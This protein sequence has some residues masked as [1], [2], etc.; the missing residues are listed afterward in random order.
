MPPEKWWGDMCILSTDVEK[1]SLINEKAQ[2]ARTLIHT[3]VFHTTQELEVA[4][5]RCALPSHGNRFRIVRFHW[6][7]YEQTVQ[8]STWQE[9]MEMVNAT[10]SG[11]SICIPYQERTGLVVLLG[12]CANDTTRLTASVEG[13]RRRLTF[14]A[15]PFSL[16]VTKELS[17]L[18]LAPA[19]FEEAESLLEDCFYRKGFFFLNME[20]ENR[21]I[22][23]ATP[24][25][26]WLRQL[27]RENAKKILFAIGKN[28]SDEI[29]SIFQNLTVE[30]QNTRVSR[31]HVIRIFMALFSS[32]EQDCPRMASALMELYG[33]D[34]SYSYQLQSFPLME[35]VLRFST[36]L[37]VD[38]MG[39]LRR[40]GVDREERIMAKI[41]AYI[42]KHY[43][44]N[45]TLN[46]IAEIVLSS[47]NYV[48]KLFRAQ[49]GEHFL[50]YLTRIRMEQAKTLLCEPSTKIYKVGEMVGYDDPTYFSKV[51]KKNVGVSP[52]EFR[53]MFIH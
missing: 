35:H 11:L 23:D 42:D 26:G 24:D 49:M 46:V 16:F 48:C 36:T 28:S 4:M 38:L 40:Q 29:T 43:Q 12:E 21:F 15:G 3:G 50:D 1:E 47:P 30:L 14:V 32:V 17:D 52:K 20:F 19:A 22:S 39:Q 10:L 8:A 27:V 7:G 2:F 51:F 41:L 9:W 44:E 5:E 6:D 34:F 37:F 53:R 31:A 18:L 25:E 13:L 45:V 33:S